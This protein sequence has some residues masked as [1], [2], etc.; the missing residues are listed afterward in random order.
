[1]RRFVYQSTR[2]AISWL[3]RGQRFKVFRAFIDCGRIPNPKLVLKIAET[4]EELEACFSILHD[5]YVESGFMTPDPSGLRVTIYHALPTTT[6]LCAKYDGQVVGTITLIRESVLGVP[7]QAIF[8]LSDVRKK[9]G[10]IAE[11]S[12]LAIHRNFRKTGGSVLF[13]LMKFMY[14]YCTTF[15]DT[16]HL[17]IAVNPSHIEMYES[18][19]FFRRLAASVV[20]SYD[21]VNGAPAVGA[22]LD[23]DEAPEV[24]RRHYGSKPRN[25]NLFAYFIET[26]L[27]NIQLPPRRF[28]TTNDPV[29][30]PELLDHF[31]NIRT[32]VFANLSDHHKVLLHSIYDLPEYKA[33]LPSLSGVERNYPCVDR[34]QKRFSVKCPARITFLA[35]EGISGDILIEVIEVS[36][37][38]FVARAHNPLP[39]NIWCDTTIQLGRA[40]VSHLRAVALSRASDGASSSCYGFRLTEPDI[41]WQKFISALSNSRTH[42]D[43]ESAELIP[44]QNRY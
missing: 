30:T 18:M 33:I 29:L 16:R 9:E 39:L 34:H 12:A 10:N 4:K 15:F 2:K 17:L 28:F 23:L 11:V 31:F 36:P 1:M 5:A 35:P 14:E 20:E 37:Y 32:K 3:P 8:D 44:A 21:F 40:D 43:L 42:C 27:S 6:T 22:T 19:L 25:R 41:L 26:R 24:F 38:D 7:A 13:P